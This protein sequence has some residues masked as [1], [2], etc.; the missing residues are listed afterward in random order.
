[1]LTAFAESRLTF[2]SSGVLVT[3]ATAEFAFWVASMERG[4]AG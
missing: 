1:M 4:P 3:R 2:V